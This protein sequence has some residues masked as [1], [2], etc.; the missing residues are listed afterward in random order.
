MPRWKMAAGFAAVVVVAAIAAGLFFLSPSARAKATVQRFLTELKYG[1]LLE[2]QAA[3]TASA[4]IVA[5]LQDNPLP[6]VRAFKVTY[7]KKAALKNTYLIG[8][9]VEFGSGRPVPYVLLSQ[10][11]AF[12]GKWKV[13]SIVDAESYSKLLQE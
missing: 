1:Q 6:D 5:G 8:A 3:E 2:M 12:D 10:K 13:V 9:D 11:D 7:V 4:E